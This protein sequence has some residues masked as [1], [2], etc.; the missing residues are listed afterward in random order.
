M[1]RGLL[2]VLALAVALLTQSASAM[3]IPLKVRR[4]CVP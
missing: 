1:K 4:V 3:D 2:E